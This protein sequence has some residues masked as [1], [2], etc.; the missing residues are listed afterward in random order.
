M[1]GP[2]FCL[3]VKHQTTPNRSA[4]YVEAKSGF[5]LPD[6]TAIGAGDVSEQVW[7]QN[8]SAG[9]NQKYDSA[10]I[11][12]PKIDAIELVKLRATAN[13]RREI[14]PNSKQK[15]GF[16]TTEAGFLFALS[17]K[18]EAGAGQRPPKPKGG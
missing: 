14:R 11:G 16:A 17:N 6:G 10:T 1:P 5:K 8:G 4:R 7:Y 13:A 12:F 3:N 18:V 9:H 15:P 2:L